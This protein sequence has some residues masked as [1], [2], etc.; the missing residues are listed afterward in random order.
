VV[1]RRDKVNP[2]CQAKQYIKANL[3]IVNSIESESGFTKII[4]HTTGNLR[5][6]S[7]RGSVL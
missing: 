1:N 5:M 4:L 2:Y 6:S 3:T 7:N